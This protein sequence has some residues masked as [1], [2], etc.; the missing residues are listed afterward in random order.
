MTSLFGRI[1]IADADYHVRI[2]EE[3]SAVGEMLRSTV[4]VTFAAKTSDLEG[5]RKAGSARSSSRC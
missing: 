2:T 5:L 1:L 3:A 4:T